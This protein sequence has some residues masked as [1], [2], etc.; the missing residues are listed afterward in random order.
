MYFIPRNHRLY[1]WFS[2]IAPTYRYLITGGS[3][4]GITALWWYCVYLPLTG[5]IS[6]YNTA[7]CTFGQQDRAYQHKQQRSSSFAEQL[8]DLRQEI[9]AYKQDSLDPQKQCAQI[10]TCIDNVG[11][12]L[13]SYTTHNQKQKEWCAYTSMQFSF[14]GT[15]DQVNSFFTQLHNTRQLMVCTHMHCVYSE[16]KT[17][18]CTCI[19]KTLDIL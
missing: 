14:V 11:L 13:R 9:D 3:L 10:L 19:I 5:T 8:D 17:F 2:H 18:L 7:T 16:Q 1:A 4:C 6:S 12:Q 15:L